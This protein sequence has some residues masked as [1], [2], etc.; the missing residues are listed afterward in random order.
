MKML[1][2]M[3]AL[4][5]TA[6]MIFASCGP[7]DPD[8]D[9]GGEGETVNV[10]SVS[11]NETTATLVVG[12]TI[13]LEAEITPA[14]ATNKNVTWESDATAIATVADG[15][16]TAV[17]PGTATITVTTEDGS[18]TATCTITVE[19]ATI[20]V[21]SVELD[22]TAFLLAFGQTAQL[23]ATI[24]PADATDPSIKG[25]ESNN[26]AVATVDANGLITAGTTAGVATITV[27]TN[28]GELTAECEV[29]VNVAG[30][31]TFL[32]NKVW[33]ITDGTITHKW[34]DVVMAAGA[35]GKESYDGGTAADGFKADV[36]ENTGYGDLFSWQV[37]EELKGQLCPS[38]WRVPSLQDF[39]D[40]DI[41]LGGDPTTWMMGMDMNAAVVAQLLDPEGW[42]AVKGGGITPNSATPPVY[43]LQYQG[44]MGC[45]WTSQ[46]VTGS[47]NNAHHVYIMDSAAVLGEMGATG[48]NAGYMLRC[49]Q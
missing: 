15:T 10:E 40:L 34:S 31:T 22:E 3:A 25:W 6:T 45:Y 9:G 21:T 4:C 43:T 47:P 7:K 38:P 5:M 19:A 8:D 32:T 16:V 26:E 1:F 13:D 42:G 39:T 2:K 20:P 28:D 36:R 44:M 12:T 23:N 14:D 41:A 35:R 17:A 33:D 46:E 24:L 11:L 48:K 30:E 18:K 49:V 37:V 27:T 29:T